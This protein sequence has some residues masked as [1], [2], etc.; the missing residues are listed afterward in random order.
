LEYS[1][2]DI[3][4]NPLQYLLEI[5]TWGTKW[6]KVMDKANEWTT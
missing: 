1:K 4:L 6:K 5:R 3:R 2:D